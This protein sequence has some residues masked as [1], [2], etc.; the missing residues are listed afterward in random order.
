VPKAASLNNVSGIYRS[1]CCGTQLVLAEFKKFPPCINP[2]SFCCKGLNAEW[3][4]MRRTSLA[5]ERW[6]L[7]ERTM[8]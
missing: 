5:T 3:I 7:P 2:K 4:L 8:S 6:I 1:D